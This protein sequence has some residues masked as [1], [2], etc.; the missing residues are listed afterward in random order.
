M[1]TS[2]SQAYT[3]LGQIISSDTSKRIGDPLLPTIHCVTNSLGYRSVTLLWDLQTVPQTDVRPLADPPC[4]MPQSLASYQEPPQPPKRQADFE[5]PQGPQGKKMCLVTSSGN[6][7][8]SP[9]SPQTPAANPLPAY[10]PNPLPAYQP[11][12]PS[13][14]LL[15]ENGGTNEYILGI[16]PGL[17]NLALALLDMQTR[18][19]IKVG[20]FEICKQ[21]LAKGNEKLVILR[22]VTAIEKFLE[23]KEP[24]RVICERNVAVPGNRALDVQV[25]GLMGYFTAKNICWSLVHAATVKSFFDGLSNSGNR[26]KNKKDALVLAR[27]LGYSPGSDHEADAL[28]L[29]HYYLDNFTTQCP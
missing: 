26:T 4:L 21:A 8:L 28:I 14:S 20:R 16:D 12:P 24:K 2:T 29:C 7:K 15:I 13:P 11:N 17:T 18:E 22:T 25:C 9:T 6:L 23:G 3:Q 27:S 5:A 19:C 1:S 10:Q